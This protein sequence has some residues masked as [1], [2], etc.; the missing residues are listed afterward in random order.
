MKKQEFT[1]MNTSVNSRNLPTA[2]RKFRPEKHDIVLDYGCGKFWRDTEKYVLDRCECALYLPFDKYNCTSF[3]NEP[4]IEFADEYGVDRVYCCN[5]LNVIKEDEIVQDII[6]ECLSF[7]RCGG[8]AVFQIY[9]GNNSGVGSPTKT[10]C[11]QRNCKAFAYGDFFKKYTV[12]KGW[13][14]LFTS[15]FVTVSKD[16]PF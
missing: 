12:S 15:S 7:L 14:V 5:V 2:F 13:H 9:S 4:S 1:S 3:Y 16:L 10:D 6:D 8:V 11:Y